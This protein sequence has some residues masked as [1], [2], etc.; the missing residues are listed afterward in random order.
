MHSS[1]RFALILWYTSTISRANTEFRLSEKGW[2][3]IISSSSHC[4]M[5]FCKHIRMLMETLLAN[6]SIA[7]NTCFDPLLQSI[8][9][10]L[11]FYRDAT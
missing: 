1:M 2:D 4:P 11:T 7:T 3:K 9:I 8:S 6:V 10:F 5:L